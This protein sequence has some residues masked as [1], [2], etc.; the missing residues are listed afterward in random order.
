MLTRQII[1]G[2]FSI[3]VIM[4]PG[5]V[6]AHASLHHS[7]PA[8]G[9]IV[10]S[11]PETIRLWFSKPIEPSFSKVKVIDQAGQQVD[12]N[13]ASVS[14]DEAKLLEISIPVLP[15]GTYKVI[16]SIVALDGHKAK[17]DFTFTIK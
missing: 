10:E 3:I 7:E 8:A 1:A 2:L 6:Y 14:G 15:A 16:W 5:Y 13:N 4:A 12:K 11:S 17:G 9:A